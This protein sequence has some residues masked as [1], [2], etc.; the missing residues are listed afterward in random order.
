MTSDEHETLTR[1]R[2]KGL[3][4]YVRRC[5]GL[6]DR[7]CGA[8][9]GAHLALANGSGDAIQETSTLCLDCLAEH[10]RR[11]AEEEEEEEERCETR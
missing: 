8:Y 3:S 11:C 7:I 1:L 4:V 10:D 9:T 2:A 6:P 5:A